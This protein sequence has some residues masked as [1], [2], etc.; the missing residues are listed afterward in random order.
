MITFNSLNFRTWS[1]L[2]LRG[3]FS[4]IASFA[5][6]EEYSSSLIVT[7]DLGYLSG[8]DRFKEKYPNRLIN[9][10][11]AEQNMIGIGAG[12]A[13][14]GHIVFATTYATFATM[15]SC[16][17]VRHFMGYMKTNLKLIG[18]GA[19]LVMGF[20]GNTHY[21]IEDIS[22]LRAIP[23]MTIVSPADSTEAVKACMAAAEFQGP[24]YIRLTGGLN[25]P[26]VYKEDYNFRIGKA[27]I[28]REGNEVTFIV[29][30]IIISNV[31]QAADILATKGIFARIVNMHT[32]KPLDSEMLE[33][34]VQDSSLIVSVEEHSRIGGLG[35][36][37]AECVCGMAKRPPV[38][39]IGID[40]EFKHA[41]DYSYLLYQNRLTPEQIA[42]A[43]LDRLRL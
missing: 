11:I 7:A 29:T 37:V 36:A 9:V 12:L 5:I 27:V 28:V 1:K 38:L 3:S 41:G 39:R 43:T 8:L 34:V 10:G 13:D 14:E 17:Q 4:A 26:M 33:N 16:E 18:S 31:I 23:N 42:T 24:V 40:D 21:T 30:G 15:R 35:A 32:V 2:G 20:S 22:M 25:V 19:G 6:A